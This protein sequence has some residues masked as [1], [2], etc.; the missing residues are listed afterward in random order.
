MATA[1]DIPTTLLKTLI[2]LAGIN[3]AFACS[4]TNHNTPQAGAT[5]NADST[6]EDKRFKWESLQALN[7]QLFTT[8][9]WGQVNYNLQ[10]KKAN[11]KQSA[12]GQ[13]TPDS[14]TTGGIDGIKTPEVNGQ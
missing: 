14:L 3:L 7:P 6:V 12:G 8:K 13:I 1:S 2:L 4:N 10:I 11:E 5:A 9:T